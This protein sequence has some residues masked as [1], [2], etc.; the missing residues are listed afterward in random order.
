MEGAD[1]RMIQRG[2]GTCLTVKALAK[3]RI[4]GD[5]GGQDFDRDGAIEA[6]VARLVDFAHA[7][8]ADRRDDFIRT[9][10]RTAR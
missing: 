3:I 10:T 7:A 2:D 1:V 4:S 5:V 9:E 6:R 8:A